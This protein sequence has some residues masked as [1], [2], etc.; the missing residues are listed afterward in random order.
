MDS[1]HDWIRRVADVAARRRPNLAHPLVHDRQCLKALVQRGVTTRTI[2]AGIGV[3]RSTVRE[4][5]RRFQI[6]PR[7]GA[8]H[9]TC[10]STLSVG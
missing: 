2:A 8:P 9:E 10:G 6:D 1:E 7:A 3:S 4:A 5:L